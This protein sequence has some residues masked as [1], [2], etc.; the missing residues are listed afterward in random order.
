MAVRLVETG[1]LRVHGC[2]TSVV[3][4]ELFADRLWSLLWPNPEGR[5]AV[6]AVES[7]YRGAKSCADRGGFRRNPLRGLGKKKSGAVP[8]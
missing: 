2:S 7:S 8:E 4:G 6:C 5:F 3:R 1:G